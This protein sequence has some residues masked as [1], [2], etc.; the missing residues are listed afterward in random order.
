[1]VTQRLITGNAAWLIFPRGLVA[2]A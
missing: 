2:A 1:V